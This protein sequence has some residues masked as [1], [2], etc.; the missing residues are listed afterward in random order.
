MATFAFGC[1]R[2]GVGLE[3]AVTLALVTLL[4]APVN[5]G[6]VPAAVAQD[7]PT[8]KVEGAM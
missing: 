1:R 5:T 2:R 7:A 3:A 6:V 8:A 4:V